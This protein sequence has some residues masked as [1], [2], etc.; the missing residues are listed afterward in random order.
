MRF[1]FINLKII[2]CMPFPVFFLVVN[3]EILER[4][5]GALWCAC[6][7]ELSGGQGFFLL[8]SLF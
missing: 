1:L 7:G 5:L 8:P 6:L 4:E 2:V 3:F